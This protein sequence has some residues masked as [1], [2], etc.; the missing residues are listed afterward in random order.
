MR[1]TYG[2]KSPGVWPCEQSETGLIRGVWGKKAWDARKGTPG[3][4]IY[5]PDEDKAVC[6]KVLLG[7]LDS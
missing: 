7:G 1:V 6:D 5:N 2:E 4:L 3:L